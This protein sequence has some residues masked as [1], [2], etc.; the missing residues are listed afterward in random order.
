[1][2]NI[3]VVPTSVSFVLDASASHEKRRDGAA[4]GWVGHT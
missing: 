1:M 2:I 3:F 4:L